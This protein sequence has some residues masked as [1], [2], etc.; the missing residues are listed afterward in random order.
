MTAMYKQH[1]DPQYCRC[2]RSGVLLLVRAE[3]ELTR[4][5]VNAADQ[6]AARTRTQD[7]GFKIILL[8]CLFPLRNF[9]P[10]ATHTT[11]QSRC[12]AN[13][14]QASAN[15]TATQPSHRIAPRRRRSCS[16]TPTTRIP[17]QTPAQASR[18][19]RS[20]RAASSTTNSVPSSIDVSRNVFV[21]MR[22]R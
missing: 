10:G 8:A 1:G 11:L 4:T 9:E 21:R 7:P 20:M 12:L 2:P 15:C 14:R 5:D 17:T 19:T 6:P 16:T 13:P 18:S 3:T 22:S